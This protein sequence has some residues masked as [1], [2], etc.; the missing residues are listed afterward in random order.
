MRVHSVESYH[1]VVSRVC[2]KKPLV[3]MLKSDVAVFFRFT[4]WMQFLACNYKNTP[5]KAKGSPLLQPG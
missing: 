2:G 3:M 5:L 4:S 1:G